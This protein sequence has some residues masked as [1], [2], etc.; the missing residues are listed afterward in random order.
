MLIRSI[1]HKRLKRFVEDDDPRGLRPDM[2]DRVGK[3]LTALLV[4]DG[5]KDL[6]SVPG[7]RVHR[8][9]GDRKGT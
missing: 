9:T 1:R 5:V 2:S 6:Q 4:A 3:V 8:L 7:W